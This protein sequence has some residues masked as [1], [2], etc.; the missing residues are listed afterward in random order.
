MIFR[1]ARSYCG[2]LLE[3]DLRAKRVAF[4]R[5][6]G[7]PLFQHRPGGMFLRITL[8]RDELQV[9]RLDAP[10][11][12]GWGDQMSTPA[13]LPAR[14]HQNEQPKLC[15][16]A[17]IASVVCLHVPSMVDFADGFLAISSHIFRVWSSC[18]L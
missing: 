17:L 7:R 1:K 14:L 4:V 3:Y 16:E 5:N 12:E 10:Y 11:S 6:K 2:S 15:S 18:A 9:L 13:F 8:R